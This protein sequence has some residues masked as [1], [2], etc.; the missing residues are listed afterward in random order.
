MHYQISLALAG[1]G[2]EEV[3]ITV[4]RNVLIVESRK[5]EKGDHQYLHQGI[6]YPHEMPL[7]RNL[8]TQIT[9]VK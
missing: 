6:P 9:R 1:F 2:P 4:E 3:T 8:H 7:A 5:A